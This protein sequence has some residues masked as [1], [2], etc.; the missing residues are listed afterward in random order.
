LNKKLAKSFH[1]NALPFN[2]VESDEFVDF[3]KALCP[4]YYQQG[5]PCRFWMETTA[6]DLV[7]EDLHHEVEEHLQ[8]CDALMASMDGW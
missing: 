3:V 6:V 7:Y 8:G 1:N 4:A 5:L 2:L